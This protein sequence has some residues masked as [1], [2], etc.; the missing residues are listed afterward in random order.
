MHHKQNNKVPRYRLSSRLN[1]LVVS[2]LNVVDQLLSFKLSK[3]FHDYRLI[4]G[5]HGRHKQPL[6]TIRQ[7]RALGGNMTS[8]VFVS[9]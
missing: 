5:V 9:E 6:K 8:T 1:S 4:A 7:L 2:I 3:D